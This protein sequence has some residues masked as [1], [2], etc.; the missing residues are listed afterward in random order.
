MIEFVENSIA[1]HGRTPSEKQLTIRICSRQE[2]AWI[3]CAT[4]EG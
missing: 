1:L 4:E 2:H 3:E